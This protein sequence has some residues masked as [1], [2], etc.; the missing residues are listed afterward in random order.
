MMQDFQV[1]FLKDSR[2]Y[3][4]MHGSDAPRGKMQDDGMGG[5]F[6][7]MGDMRTEQEIF[8]ER[9]ER[10]LVAYGNFSAQDIID[11]SVYQEEFTHLEPGLFDQK[12]KASQFSNLKE[13]KKNAQ[14]KKTRAGSSL[15]V[16]EEDESLN[17][18]MGYKLPLF[19]ADQTQQIGVISLK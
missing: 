19:T 6:Q 14:K 11:H 3:S 10:D 2:D 9:I 15:S 8:L 1:Y 13:A 16:D 17:D 5:G 4:E 18:F 7:P 12:K